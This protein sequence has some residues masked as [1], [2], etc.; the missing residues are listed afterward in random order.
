MQGLIL[1]QPP[2]FKSILLSVKLSFIIDKQVRVWDYRLLKHWKLFWN[3]KTLNFWNALRISKIWREFLKCTNDIWNALK[4]S[5]MQREFDWANRDWIK[6][7]SRKLP[8]LTTYLSSGL[9]WFFRSSHFQKTYTIFQPLDPLFFS[10]KL[11]SFWAQVGCFKRTIHW[12]LHGEESLHSFNITL[13]MM[14]IFFYL[15]IF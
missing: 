1:P 8:I 10:E 13:N 6:F 15:L 7:N 5:K 12:W 14:N 11:T 2:F 9:G 3:I 4:K